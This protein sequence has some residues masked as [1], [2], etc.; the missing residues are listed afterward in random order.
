MGKG[1][2]EKL[3]KEFDITDTWISYEL[4][5]ETPPEGILLSERFRGRDV[6]KM[7]DHLRQRGKEFGIVFV[8]RTLLS[9]S[10]LALEASEYARDMGK[11]EKFNDHMFHAYFTEALNIGEVETLSIIADRCGLDTAGLMNALKDH[12]FKPRLDEAKKEGRRINL[13]GVPT[14]IINEKYKVIGAQPV[15]AFS[16]ILNKIT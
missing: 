6:S 13:T 16:E 1:I 8:D 4:H 14:F 11:H 5:P 15:E 7:Y 10:R 12:T 9:N 3:K 2:V